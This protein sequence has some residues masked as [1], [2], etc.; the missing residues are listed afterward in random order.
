MTERDNETRLGIPTET[1]VNPPRQEP[2]TGLE[3]VMPT[4]LVD[5]PSEG[6]FYPVGHP[7]RG[8]KEIEIRY[9]TAKEEDILTSKSLLKKGVAIDKMLESIVVDRS[10]RLEDL[11]LG[12]KNALI[13]AARKT[14]YGPKYETLVPCPK[15]E[16][17]VKFSFDLDKVENKERFMVGGV[18]ETEHGTFFITLPTMKIQ[19]E[20]KPITGKDEKIL[21]ETQEEKKKAGVMEGNSTTQMKLFI[22]TVNGDTNRTTINRTVDRMPASDA[23]FLREVYKKLIPDVDMSQRFVCSSCDYE[24]V[25]EI[26]LTTDF[27][28]P[29]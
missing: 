22:V 16:T 24:E 15:C 27:F 18:T 14:G 28:W 6:K 5:L 23:R 10:I 11:V 2:K 1:E 9:M 19:V 4:E 26:P 12:D 25:V 17:K 29:K 13:L 20:V 8:K 21:A 3:F 7:L